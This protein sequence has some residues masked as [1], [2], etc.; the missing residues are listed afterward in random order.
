MGGDGG[1]I[2]SRIDLVRT[3]GY[4]FSRNLG[5]MG[6]LPNTQC[7]ANNEHLSSNQ[8]KELRWKT[9]ALSQEPLSPPIVS[10]KLGLLY[11]KEAVLKFILSKKPNPS[12][13]HLKGL[14][15]IKD[16]EFLVDK[17]TGR[18]LCPILRTELSATNRAVLIWNCGCC[19]SEKAFKQFMKNTTEAQCP[20]CNTT[21]KY[22]PE[23]FNKSQSLPFNSDL[24]FL[25]PDL[26][27]EGI[28]RTK[29]LHLK[30]LKTQ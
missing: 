9:C 6:Y 20:N 2:P 17:G 18:F 11:N 27:E 7:R 29:L 21:F 13:E 30:S 24:V 1:S 16:I 4:A 28:L 19:M 3:S 23:V 25:V 12:F 15:D 14:K 10:C 22:N 5:G 26:T 8:I